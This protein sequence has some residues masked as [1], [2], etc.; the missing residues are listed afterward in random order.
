[1]FSVMCVCH[2][3]CPQGGHV[4][5]TYDTFDL[6]VQAPAHPPPHTRETRGTPPRH[7]QT[8]SLDLTVQGPTPGSDIWWPLKE[9]RSEQ[10]GGKHPTGMH[11]CY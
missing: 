4:T 11:P 5:I 7:V 9:S 6:A 2:S 1:M 3:V 10:A 8:C